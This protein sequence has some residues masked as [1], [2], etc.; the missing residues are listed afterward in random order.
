MLFKSVYESIMEQ[1]KNKVAI[2][3][4]TS[5]G[6]GESIVVELVKR[7]IHVVALARR[8][9]KLQVSNFFFLIIVFVNKVFFKYCNKS[10]TGTYLL[11]L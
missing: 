11:L 7:G 6:I 10:K 8:E 9:D 2:V 4:G 3:T 1:W 5:A